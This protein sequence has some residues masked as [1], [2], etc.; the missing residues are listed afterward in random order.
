MKRLTGELKGQFEDGKKLEKEIKSAESDLDRNF[1][2]W[3]Q[4][5][6]RRVGPVSSIPG[7]TVVLD[8]PTLVNNNS[9]RQWR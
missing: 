9:V 5:G 3:R 1:P 6:A 7:I 2:W 8:R 4:M